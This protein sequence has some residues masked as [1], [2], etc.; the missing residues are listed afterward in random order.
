MIKLFGI[1]SQE[2]AAIAAAF[3]SFFLTDPEAVYGR[4]VDR[5]PQASRRGDRWVVHSTAWGYYGS[6]PK[7]LEGVCLR[8]LAL[9]P[10]PL[11][12]RERR[13][14]LYQCLRASYEAWKEDVAKRYPPPEG[15]A[16]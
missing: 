15:V 1:E 6:I 3:G 16:K 13:T 10:N 9:C 11:P 14:L 4:S 7:S 8:A 12:I 5:R 2:G